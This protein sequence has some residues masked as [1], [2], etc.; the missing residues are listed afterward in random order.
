MCSVNCSGISSEDTSAYFYKSGFMLQGSQFGFTVS[1]HVPTQS[2]HKPIP[3]ITLP[4]SH[5][6]E[7]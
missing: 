2:A 6:S 5:Q 1:P 3:Q 4:V 7:T